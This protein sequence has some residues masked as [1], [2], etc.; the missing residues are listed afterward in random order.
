MP[1]EEGELTLFI[2]RLISDIQKPQLVPAFNLMPNLH[3]LPEVQHL[4]A[5]A[6]V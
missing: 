5:T 4:P 2:K 3:P 6:S 1:H